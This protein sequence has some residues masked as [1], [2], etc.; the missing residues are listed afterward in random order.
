MSA[1]SFARLFPHTPRKFECTR[2]ITADQVMA[3]IQRIPGFGTPKLCAI[4]GMESEY[5]QS[6]LSLIAG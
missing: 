3:T 6:E 2:L 5:V 4:R 1:S